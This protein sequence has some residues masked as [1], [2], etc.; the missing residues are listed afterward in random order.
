MREVEVADCKGEGFVG[1][2][3]DGVAELEVGADAST[4]GLDFELFLVVLI[5]EGGEGGLGFLHFFE[6]EFA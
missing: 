4:L 2:G 6:E 3:G 5:A 1:D